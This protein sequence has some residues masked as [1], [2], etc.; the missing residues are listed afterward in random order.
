MFVAS[1]KFKWSVPCCV[2][3]LPPPFFP[4]VRLV[5][6]L[7][8]PT[9]RGLFLFL[10]LIVAGP[11]FAERG[12]V[13]ANEMGRFG[14]VV[15]TFGKEV[16]AKARVVGTVMIVEFDQEVQLD[17]E[18]VAS[19]IPTYISIARRDPDGKSIRFGLTDRMTPDLKLAG[20]R[21]YLDILP[22]KWQGLPPSLPPEV[23]QDLVRRTKQA[24]EQ[25]RQFAK[26][27]E[28]QTLRDLELSVGSTAL[29]KR[30]IF[31]MP[32]VAGVQFSANDGLVTLIFDANFK[33]AQT[34]VRSRLAG[35]VRDVDVETGDNMLRITM[36]AMEG[37]TIRG[38]REDDT[39]TLDFTRQDGQSIEQAAAETPAAP[40][41]AAQ[42][43]KPVAPPAAKA[44]A[45]PPS[46]PSD[47]LPAASK[48]LVAKLPESAPVEAKPAAAKRADVKSPEARPVRVVPIDSRM[49]VN[50][51]P[52]ELALAAE[53]DGD[54]FALAFKNLKNAPIAAVPSDKGLLVVLETDQMPLAPA[55]PDAIK[56]NVEKVSLTRVKGGALIHLVARGEGGFWL[57]K[58]GPDLMVHHTRAGTSPSAHAGAPAV[59]RRA[60]D[61]N[62]KDIVE[63]DVGAEGSLMAVDDP[64]TGQRI[65]VL[66]APDAAFASSKS[67]SYVNFAIERTLAG[68]A[69][70]PLD[71]AVTIR[72]EHEKVE[73]GHDIKLNVSSLPPE[74]QL[75]KRRSQG[76][77][78]R[79]GG[80]GR[81]RPFAPD[82]RRASADTQRRRGLTWCKPL[83]SAHGAGTP[84]S[85]ARAIRGG[86]RRSRCACEGR[87]CRCGNQGIAVPPRACCRDVGPYN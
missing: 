27:N 66:P 13:S 23:I 84:L 1:S 33:I 58:S 48:P 56:Q 3:D 78:A 28:R 59:L 39:F 10:A 14:R 52:I 9:P 16:V 4:L 37:L 81:R 32:R 8:A 85:G 65:T 86:G 68:L 38:F 26:D 80:M 73:I 29:F 71:E 15:F 24:E 42:E 55:I 22:S 34:T 61:K 44:A 72:R 19:Q 6:L 79:Y 30:A 31:A 20:E 83:G 11:A 51:G 46:K 47:D 2:P 69:I 17:L 82:A 35:L 74:E 63:I 62:G 75:S 64:A 49:A 57:S 87:S 36:R 40:A 12:I 7:A 54:G 5:R 41:K 43:N 60:F 45:A 70:L 25:V 53:T 67:Q 76:A 21:I 18:K 77:D 50:D